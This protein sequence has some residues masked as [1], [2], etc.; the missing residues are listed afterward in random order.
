VGH[1]DTRVAPPATWE[2]TQP[3]SR[4]VESAPCFAGRV[5]PPCEAPVENWPLSRAGDDRAPVVAKAEPVGRGLS[6]D[7]RFNRLWRFFWCFVRGHATGPR[8]L[9]MVTDALSSHRWD[10]V[11]R[12]H[13]ARAAAVALRRD[14]EAVEAWSVT[15]KPARHAG[16]APT[17]VPLSGWSWGF[18]DRWCGATAAGG[19]VEVGARRPRRSNTLAS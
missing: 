7:G 2:P 17:T 3:V 12:G 15:G 13:A 18:R 6:G 14:R 1:P 5:H 16:A 8:G 9:A 10:G 19:A 11:G 4:P